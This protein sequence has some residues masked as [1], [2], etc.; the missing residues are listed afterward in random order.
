MMNLIVAM[1]KKWLEDS[2]DVEMMTFS[3]EDNQS[4]CQC[5][6]CAAA[7]NTYG[8]NAAQVIKFMNRLYQKL[9]PWLTENGRN[10]VLAFFAYH[11]TVDA[12][13][14]KQGDTYLPIDDS[15]KCLNNVAVMYAP[16][17][18]DYTKPLTN[19]ANSREYENLMKWKACSNKTL[20]WTYSTDFISYLGPYNTYDSIVENYRLAV[21]SGA[22]WI[23]DQQQKFQSNSTAFHV[24]KYYLQA[25]LAWNV[26]LDENELID[27]F[28]KNYFG[29]AKDVMQKLFNE[30][31]S[32]MK[33]IED[34][35][36]VSMYIYVALENKDYWPKG[37]LLQWLEYIESAKKTIEYL[38]DQDE[39]LY[40]LIYDRI[41]LESISFRFL[42]ID[43]YGG[44]VYD[45]ETLLA[46]KVA[47]K[48]DCAYLRV[49]RFNE[50]LSLS[51]YMNRNW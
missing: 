13:A 7:K 48:N 27:D 18:A 3:Q 11:E 50:S 38:K 12:P 22:F 46:E 39:D 40:S 29:T 49:D 42:L 23:L 1:L 21:K 34:E 51:E 17:E 41:L 10:L 47:F 33:Y 31:R 2:P 20:L 19:E 26:N 43:I 15:V 32:R 14:K 30:V 28:F 6:K 35:L 8:T 36:H 45:A 25:K 44:S 37:L 5:N 16:I 9:E 4:W 24:L